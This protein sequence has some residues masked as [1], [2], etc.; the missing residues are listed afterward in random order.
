[1]VEQ[2]LNEQLSTKENTDTLIKVVFIHQ[3]MH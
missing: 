1:L 3:L 2:S